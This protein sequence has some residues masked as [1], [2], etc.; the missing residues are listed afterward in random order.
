M[1][2]VNI[3]TSSLQQVASSLKLYSS[4]MKTIASKMEQRVRSMESWNDE[5]AQQFIEQTTM[6]CQG[7]HL[8]MDNFTKMALFLDK[9]AKQQEE[10]E[11]AMKQ[12]I[13]NIK[14]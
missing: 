1:S 12:Q 5:R 10:V 14:K 11:R 6:V 9:F 13:N 7:L 4:E 2:N 8:N 3:T